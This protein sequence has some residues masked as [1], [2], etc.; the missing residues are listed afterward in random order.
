MSGAENKKFSMSW[1]GLVTH[2]PV[3]N[4]TQVGIPYFYEK[5]LFIK[6]HIT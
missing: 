4:V 2:Y 1:G 5:N 3:Q 6:I